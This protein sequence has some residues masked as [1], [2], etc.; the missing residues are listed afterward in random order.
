VSIWWGIG[1]FAVAAATFGWLQGSLGHRHGPVS[2]VLHA[3]M[4]PLTWLG[5]IG[6]V[7]AKKDWE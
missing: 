4:W 2:I 1:Y 3:A 5:I 7:L 6:I